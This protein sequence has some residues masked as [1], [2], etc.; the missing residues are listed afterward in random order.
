MPQAVTENRTFSVHA[1]HVDA[2]HARTL[3]EPSFEAAAVAYVEDL[4]DLPG[5]GDEISV[6]VREGRKRS[7]AL[8]PCRSGDRRD[9]ALRLDRRFGTG[10]DRQERRMDGPLA[11]CGRLGRGDHEPAEGEF[12]RSPWGL[13]AAIAGAKTRGVHLVRLTDDK[14][15]VLVPASRDPFETLC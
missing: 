7:P 6:I 15:D 3:Q 2:H 1:R 8:L 12:D 5:D 14:G 11:R 10:H 13:K 4:H 9:L